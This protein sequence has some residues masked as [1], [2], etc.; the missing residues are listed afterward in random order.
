VAF[1]LIHNIVHDA[2]VV[3]T[4]ESVSSVESCVSGTSLHI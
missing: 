3:R 2:H 4:V 1:D